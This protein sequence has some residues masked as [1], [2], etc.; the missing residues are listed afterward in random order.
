MPVGNGGDGIGTKGRPLKTMVHLKRCIIKVKAENNC[1]AYA[2]V[3]DVAKLT[4]EQ[5]LQSIS[6]RKK[7]YVLLW[8]VYFR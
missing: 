7:R 4:N 8:I 3:I 1:I 5:K 2:L 6:T